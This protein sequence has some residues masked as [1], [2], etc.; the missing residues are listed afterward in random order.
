MKGKSA[1]TFGPI[2]PWLVTTDEVPNP[3]NLELWLEVDGRSYQRST[4]RHM[5][6][7]VARLVS[8]ISG[9][10]SLHPG[11]IISTGT[12]P[13]IGMG[14]QPPVYLRPGNHVRLGIHSL[15]E[16]SQRVTAADATM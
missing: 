1:D 10:M 4:T 3:Q 14:Q 11:D 6:F 8:Y 5:I 16:Q 9:F 13:G 15:G 7:S 2:G 12:P